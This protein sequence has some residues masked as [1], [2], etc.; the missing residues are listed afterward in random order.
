MANP[1]QAPALPQRLVNF[2]A[3]YPPQLHSAAVRR[4]APRPKEATVPQTPLPSPYTSDRDA[5]GAQALKPTEWTPAKALLV[6]SDTVRNPFLPHKRFGKWESPRYGLRQQ[7]D[8]MKL[9]IKYKVETLLPPSRK[10]PEFKDKRRQERGLQVKGTGIGQKVKGHKWERTMESRLEDRRKAME[11]MPEMVRMWKQVMD[12]DGSNGPSGNGN[13]PTELVEASFYSLFWRVCSVLAFRRHT[14]SSTSGAWDGVLIFF[15]FLSK[16]TTNTLCTIQT[17]V[18]YPNASQW[19]LTHHIQPLL[20]R[21]PV[22]KG[23]SFG[24]S[25][26]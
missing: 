8:L 15:L 19:T 13:A 21:S 24:V 4:P 16:Y 20:L 2:F 5:K 9:A 23:P 11:G 3:R 6:T 1:A 26:Y 12:V 10:S 18:T 25:D 14:G 7:A 17:A 22:E